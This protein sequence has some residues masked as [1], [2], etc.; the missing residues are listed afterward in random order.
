MLLGK[1]I[2]AVDDEKVV[3]EAVRKA[4][5]KDAYQIDTVESAGEA[6]E[7]LSV[8]SYDV[9]ISDLM[10]P[11]IDGLELIERVGEMGLKVPSVMITGYPT[12][13]TALRAKR[14][15]AFE[16]VTKPFTREELRSVVVRAIRWGD[17]EHRQSRNRSTEEPSGSRYYIPDHAWAAVEENGSVRIGMTREFASTIGK[18]AGL[19]LPDQNAYI[20]Q[21]RIFAQVKAADGIEHSLHCPLSGGVLEVNPMVKEHAGLAGID[22]E[23]KGWLLRIQPEDLE[24]EL[25]NLVPA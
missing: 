3:L 23:G 13:K 8:V 17:E 12:I 5:R 2:L 4:L 25:P 16:Y 18:V 9:M 24:G 1:R 7:L 21:G 10:M 6:L 15:G 20:E 11:E 14:L 22:P 19:Q